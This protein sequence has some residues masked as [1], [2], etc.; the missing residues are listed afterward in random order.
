MLVIITVALLIAGEFILGLGCGCS[1]AWWPVASFEFDV[2]ERD[3]HPDRLRIIHDG[4][5]A[6]TSEQ[7]YIEADIPFRAIDSDATA[8]DRLSWR[9]LGHDGVEVAAG[10]RVLLEPI[11]PNRSIYEATF[12]IRWLGE[13]FDGESEWATL[14]RWEGEDRQS[15]PTPH[16][17]IASPT[18][19]PIETSDRTPQR[20]GDGSLNSS[21][22]TDGACEAYVENASTTD[23]PTACQRD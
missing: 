13:N 4:G 12:D 15:T 3:D 11:D 9:D 20:T 10:D 19:S 7:L 16:A 22:W 8:G 2:I 23:T 18:V 17:T 1:K 6:A 21:I 14:G 5:D